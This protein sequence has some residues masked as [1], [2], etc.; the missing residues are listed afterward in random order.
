MRAEKEP[1]AG[2]EDGGGL[3]GGGCTYVHSHSLILILPHTHLKTAACE[4][5]PLWVGAGV[6]NSSEGRGGG[7]VACPAPADCHGRKART[8]ASSSFLREARI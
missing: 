8:A 7:Q 1:K 6:T 3:K 4:D 5:L 2:E